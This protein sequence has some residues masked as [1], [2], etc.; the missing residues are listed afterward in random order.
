MYLQVALSLFPALEAMGATD[1]SV[2]LWPSV[3]LAA[4]QTAEILAALMDVG[5]SRI[6]PEYSFL[7]PRGVGGLENGRC[8]AARLDDRHIIVCNAN[9]DTLRSPHNITHPHKWKPKKRPPTKKGNDPWCPRNPYIYPPLHSVLSVLD[10]LSVGDASSPAWRPPRG[11]DGTPPESVA[12]VLVRVQQLLSLLETQYSGA[13][14]LIVSPDSDNL[15]VLQAAVR[16]V[17]LRQ[18]RQQFG[19]GVGEVRPLMLS[20]TPAAAETIRFACP[21]PPNCFD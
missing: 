6:V 10:A 5:R 15:S 2:W 16:G 7:D 14:V 4:Y 11:F 17:D 1:G 9:G 19:M 13:N 21:K 3:H 8:V 20:E 12:D 18:H